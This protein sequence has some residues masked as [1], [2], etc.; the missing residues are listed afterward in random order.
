M[1]AASQRFSQARA[2]EVG[3]YRVALGM[4][5][6]RLKPVGK[7]STES[8]LGSD[9][10][11]ALLAWRRQTRSPRVDPVCHPFARRHRRRQ[12]PASFMIAPAD[13]APLC[14]LTSRPFASFTSV[15]M[16]RMP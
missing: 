2:D 10:V 16:L 11:S 1:P 14:R 8:A 6:A 9:L 3:L 12:P 13:T 7:G 15:G 4:H 5:P